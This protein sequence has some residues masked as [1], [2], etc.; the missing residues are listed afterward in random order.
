MQRPVKV[1]EKT[2]RI[3]PLVTVTEGSQ[4]I[5]TRR[6]RTIRPC[7]LWMISSREKHCGRAR[8]PLLKRPTTP[9]ASNGFTCM[10]TEK[11]GSKRSC[12]TYIR[13]GWTQSGVYLVNPCLYSKNE[14]YP[15]FIPASSVHRPLGIKN[16]CVVHFRKTSLGSM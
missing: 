6:N 1:R 8:K 5:D 13:R 10:R 4:S 16:L 15:P 11:P 12:L 3:V 9:S 14:F 2:N 7:A